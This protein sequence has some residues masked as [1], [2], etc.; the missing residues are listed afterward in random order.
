MP[1]TYAAAAGLKKLAGIGVPAGRINEPVQLASPKAGRLMQTG[2]GKIPCLKFASGTVTMPAA[3]KRL[4]RRF[5]SEKKKKVFLISLMLRP[6]SP[7][8]GR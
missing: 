7:N 5:S 2:I 6:P 4:S 8:L 1:A 3:L